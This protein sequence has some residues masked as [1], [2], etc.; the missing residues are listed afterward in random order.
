MAHLTDIFRH[1]IKAHGV[2]R[3]T[4]SPVAVNECLPWD[5]VWAVAHEKAKLAGTN[6]ISCHNFT[7]AARTATVHAIT[8]TLDTTTGTVTLSHPDRKDFTFQPDDDRQLTGFLAWMRPL[9]VDAWAQSTHIVRAG[10][11]AMTDT[12]F[13]SISLN[14]QASRRALSQHV[15]QD[16]EMQRFRGNLWVDGLAPF[17][18]HEWVGKTVRIGTAEFEGVEPIERC[19]ATMVNTRTGQRDAATLDTLEARYGHKDFG[20]FL[21]CTKPGQIAVNDQVTVL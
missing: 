7:R 19:A 10:S 4:T 13:P 11:Q 14:N 5:R 2:E 12:D 16:L 3:I 6:W 15:G 21:R 8:S 18:D 1:P 20:I 9:M 17:E